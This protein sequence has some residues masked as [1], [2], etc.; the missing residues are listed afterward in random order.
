MNFRWWTTTWSRKQFWTFFVFAIAD[1]SSAICV[2]LQAPF[3]PKEAERKGAT[4]A[5]YGLVFGIFELTV[6]IVSPLLGKNLGRFGVKRVFNIGILTTGTCSILF[7]LLDKIP[8]GTTFIALSFVI[9][10]LEAVGNSG[11]L[12]ASFSI[13]AKEFP[14]RVATM[15]ATLETFFGIGLIVGPTVGGALYQAGGYSL[16][17]AALG[18]LLM[19]V[20]LMTYFV[21]PAKYDEDEANEDDSAQSE[22]KGMLDLLKIPS[23]SLA[24]YSILNASITIGYIQATL[25]P[26]LRQFNL[27]PVTMGKKLNE[28]LHPFRNFRFQSNLNQRH[29]PFHTQMLI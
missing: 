19:S 27:T 22:K 11:F 24:A 4:P 1:F 6:F 13:I 8:D 16:P 18:G 20:A 14:D 2:S 7:G 10:T 15:F 17:F 12:T 21:L 5:E 3:Y 25:E 23:I 26:H 29:R 28:C 9:R